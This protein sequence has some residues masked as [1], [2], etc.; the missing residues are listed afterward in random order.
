M[1]AIPA[2]ICSHRCLQRMSCFLLGC[3][4][5][6]KRPKV[7]GSCFDAKLSTHLG[8][9]RH[10]CPAHLRWRGG[11]GTGPM[12]I[13]STVVHCTGFITRARGAVGAFRRSAAVGIER[14]PGSASARESRRRESRK[15]WFHSIQST[16]GPSGAAGKKEKK[17]KTMSAGAVAPCGCGP[18]GYLSWKSPSP[19]VSRESPP[20]GCHYPLS[21]CA[22]AFDAGL[23]RIPRSSKWGPLLARGRVGWDMA[24]LGA[25]FFLSRNMLPL[26]ARSGLIP[27]FLSSFST[28]DVA[29]CDGVLCCAASA[30]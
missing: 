19:S 23:V 29:S 8:P 14:A 18:Q 13:H 4:E 11:N 15:A 21:R 5:Y 25:L 30:Y 20:R 2:Q 28:P 16:L 27:S 7:S 6:W 26:L 22:C 17:K 12:H 24:V 10:A 3:N 9:A 1:H